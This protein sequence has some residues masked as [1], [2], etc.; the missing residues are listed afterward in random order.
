MKTIKNQ[1]GDAGVGM[2][3]VMAVMM[4]GAWLFSGHDGEH[5]G[6]GHHMMNEHGAT[7]GEQSRQEEPGTDPAQTADA[8]GSIT[9][10]DQ[11]SALVH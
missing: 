8:S 11:L 6:G 1:R 10:D 9:N 5:V 2:L 4:L 3:V 7:H